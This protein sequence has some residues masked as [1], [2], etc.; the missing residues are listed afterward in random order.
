MNC[1]Q[2]LKDQ[3]TWAHETM[4]A[5]MAD[6]TSEVA[7]S[8]DTSKAMPVGAAYAHCV[9]AED[10][11]VSSMLSN[12]PSL[13]KD[14]L[15]V[16][17]SVLLPAMDHWD[18]HEHWYKTVKVDLVKLKVFA[19]QVYRASDDYLSGLSDSD[20]EKE[21]DTGM[22]MGNKSLAWVVSNF[23]ILHTANLTGEVSAA[24]GFQGL[25]GYPF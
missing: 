16:G 19:Q 24:K 6:V 3:L 21:M 7:N 9:L 5:T 2:L 11:V 14:P 17:G 18:Q 4:E 15:E 22:G 10:M 23:V 13:A 12:Q 20:L 1:V 8:P 25:K